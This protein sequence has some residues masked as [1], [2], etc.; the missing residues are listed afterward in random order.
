MLWTVSQASLTNFTTYLPMKAPVKLTSLTICARLKSSVLFL[1]KR[2]L[3]S[4]LR[5]LNRNKTSRQKR[6]HQAGLEDESRVFI[7]N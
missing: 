2:V 6:V 5:D 4:V 3:G 1:H 7:E